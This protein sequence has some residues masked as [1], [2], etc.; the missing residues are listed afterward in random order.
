M[1][2]RYVIRRKIN[3]FARRAGWPRA[4]AKPV[5]AWLG[6]TT[7]CNLNCRVCNPHLFG[8][9][10][11]DMSRA[12]FERVRRELLPGLRE[13]CLSTFG[14]PFVAPVTYA[15]IDALLATDTRVWIITNGTIIQREYLERLVRSPS[16][17]I[18]SVDGI[19]PQVY[20]YIRRGGRFERVME[21]LETVGALRAQGGHPDFH[22]EINFIVTRSTVAQLVDCIELAHRYGVSAVHFLSFIVAGRRDEF[23]VRESLIDRPEDVLPYW[24]RARRRGL[25]LGI[26]VSPMVFDCCDRPD[27]Q[28]TRAEVKLFGPNGRVRQCPM[29]WWWTFV[30][31]DGSVRPCC[32]WPPDI[33][34]GNLRTQRLRAIWNGP[35]YRGLRRTVNTLSMPDPCQRC[36][37][38]SRL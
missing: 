36:S 38:P 16:R 37:L 12:V 3:S 2:D 11:S 18:V 28:R 4:P 31:V 35:K 1:W 20:E 13:A 29:P 27:E 8:T 30:D 10:F 9:D 23:A 21:F 22:L 6:S 5:F 32:A 34:F 24:Q 7:R 14:E 15:M 33:S 19:T 25:Q 26:W 17:I